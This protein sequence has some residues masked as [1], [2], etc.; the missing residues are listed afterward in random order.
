M[1]KTSKLDA[2]QGDGRVQEERGDGMSMTLQEA[3]DLHR[4]RAEMV[5]TME[6]L[7]AMND[8]MDRQILALEKIVRLLERRE[9]DGK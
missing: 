1:G 2:F 8:K 4:V 7:K 6:M 9:D 3:N 5:V